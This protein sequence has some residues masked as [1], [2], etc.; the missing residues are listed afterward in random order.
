MDVLREHIGFI[1]QKAFLFNGTIAENIR[2]GKEDAT[3]EEMVHAAKIAQAYDF[4]MEK[5]YPV[6]RGSVSPLQGRL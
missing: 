5:P 4:I 6:D 3:T 1:P 2:F